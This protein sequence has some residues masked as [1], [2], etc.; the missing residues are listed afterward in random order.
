MSLF[1]W[2]RKTIFISRPS[3]WYQVYSDGRIFRRTSDQ[4]FLIRYSFPPSVQSSQHWQS[5]TN[6]TISHAQT[7]PRWFIIRCNGTTAFLHVVALRKNWYAVYN[8]A[9]ECVNKYVECLVRVP[10]ILIALAFCVMV[11][12]HLLCV[13][14]L[15]FKAVFRPSLCE[16]CSNL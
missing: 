13:L 12:C 9:E 14:C 5:F 3:G 10:S 7:Y 4:M 15:V 11:F 1:N 16:F 6:F 8:L 2:T